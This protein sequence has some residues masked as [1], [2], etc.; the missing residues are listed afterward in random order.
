MRYVR[1]SFSTVLLVVLAACSPVAGLLGLDDEEDEVA[2]EMRQL[3][4]QNLSVQ[5]T[6]EIR[7]QPGPGLQPFVD[8]EIRATNS[9]EE[10]IEG[11]ALGGCHW[12][13]RFYEPG[14]S[15]DEPVFDDRGGGA[16]LDM[17]R[18]FRVNPGETLVDSVTWAVDQTLRDA[19]PEGRYSVTVALM[20]DDPEVESPEF[21]L[22]EVE[23][24]R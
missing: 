4:E 11:K 23:L 16:C 12:H 21:G 5:G 3:A 8:W 7:G 18:T 19:R 2:T 6:Y 13:F 14:G 17:Y 15:S 22:G 1:F 9:G 24:R 20:L 10:P